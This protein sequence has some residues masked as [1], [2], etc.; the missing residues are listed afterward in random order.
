MAN[1][2]N[3]NKVIYGNDTLIDLTSDTVTQADVLNSKSFHDASGTLRTGTADIS[4]KADLTD[5]A[6]AFSDEQAYSKGDYVTYDGDLY[7]FTSNKSAG[8]WDSTRA[9]QITVADELSV[10]PSKADKIQLAPEFSTSSSYSAGSYCTFNGKLYRFDSSKSAGDW[11][12]S[13]VTEVTVGSELR[14]KENWTSFSS[15]DFLVVDLAVEHQ[16]PQHNVSLMRADS[17]S[18]G[19]DGVVSADQVSTALNKTANPEMIAPTFSSS[20]AYWAGDYVT[21]LDGII[22]AKVKLF[23]FTANHTGSWTGLDVREVEVATVLNTKVDKVAGKGLSTNDYDN[24]AK[25]IVDNI[26]DALDGKVS[27]EDNTILGAKNFCY[28]LSGR[29]VTDHEVTATVMDDGSIRLNGTAN[30]DANIIMTERYGRT[31]WLFSVPNGEYIVSGATSDVNIWYGITASSAYSKLAEDTGSG[32]SLTIDGDDGSTTS[33]NLQMALRIASGK[34]FS[35]TKI[36]P[37][38]RL[39]DDT[40]S[41]YAPYAKTNKELTNDKVEW[42]ANTV[43]GAKNLLPNTG[44]SIAKNGM[45]YTVNTDGS[46]TVSGTATATHSFYIATGSF[47]S[48]KD[49]IL[50][51]CPAGGSAETYCLELANYA[52]KDTGSGIAK[53]GCLIYNTRILIQNGTAISTPITFRPMIRLA[54]DFDATYAPY[55]KTNREL[56][57]DAFTRGEQSVLGAKNLLKN[58]AVTTTK[59]N[60]TYTVNAD[61]TVTVSTTNAGASADTDLTL[62]SYV[63]GGAILDDTLD[64]KTVIL[65]GCP[66]GGSSTTYH[67]RFYNYSGQSSGTIPV[68]TDY[69]YGTE[70]F[71]VSL[72]ANVYINVTIRVKSG[73]I[74][75]T[76]VTFSPMIR[77]ASDTDDTYVPYAMTNKELMD[78]VFEKRELTSADNLDNITET[79]IYSVSTAPTNMPDG[80]TY[81]TVIVKYRTSGNIVQEVIASNALYTRQY[82]GSPA[83]WSAWT[84][85]AKTA[86]PAFTG[87]PTAPTATAGTNTTQIATTAFVQT[88]IDNAVTS[89]LSASY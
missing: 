74:I 86:S 51:G 33:A 41:T 53:I 13:K 89:A 79:G 82:G 12:Y 77:L 39:A 29:S 8:A 11:S 63:S 6:D 72:S 57:T 34:S 76:P 58:V 19:G 49:I 85:Y 65:S 37:M 36:Y 24:T 27:W 71:T 3:I 43:L 40:D 47:D 44:V 50:T 69:G 23:Q 61:G 81:C 15:G 56:T 66:S 26:Q 48:E 35:D 64:D 88:A 17:V 18:A 14:Q 21:K 80:K 25:S 70:P 52:L 83:S 42:S 87:T 5:L 32:A 1:N 22:D 78:K 4:G 28:I 10:L 16:L 67:L 60:V 46:V 7:R 84:S 68:A 38:I 2:A 59:N 9:T 62:K 31:G 54:S 73:A 55:A 30:G 45:T 20:Q 75:T